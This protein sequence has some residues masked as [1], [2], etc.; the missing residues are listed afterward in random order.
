MTL[1]TRFLFPSVLGVALLLLLGAA[2]PWTAQAEGALAEGG[3]I[4]PRIVGGTEVDPPGKYP[5][6]V[7]VV[8]ASE[9]DTYWGQF[10]GGSL[11]AP[12]W[13]LTAGH[14]VR[15][16][17]ANAAWKLDVVVG[18]HDLR[19]GT[20]GER[21]G[22]AGIYRH[23]GYDNWTLANDLALLRLER[24]AT[25]GSP[26]DL[27]TAANAPLFST[28]EIA[29]V[30]GWGATYEQPPGTPQYPDELREVRVPVVS[31]IQCA[32]AY[33]SDLILPD[34]LC[35]GDM[36]FGGV[37]SC[38]GDSGGP[39]FVEVDAAIEP[40]YLHIGIVSSG[41]DCALPGWPGLYT[42]TANYT[43]W[44][45]S[46]LA[47]PPPTC[48]GVEATILGSV[49]DDTIEGTEGD[50]VIAA[51]A[52]DDVI[53]GSG[54]HDLI[55]GG[56]GDDRVDGGVGDDA[57]LG[58]AGNDRLEGAEGN[59]VLRGGPGDDRLYGGPGEDRLFGGPGADLALG[60]EGNDVVYGGGA[61]DRL[62]GGDGDDWVLGRSGDDFLRGG[63]GDDNLVGDED[64]DVLRGD[65]GIDTCYSGE[66]V[67]CEVLRAGSVKLQ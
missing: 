60:E 4:D 25:L 31:D 57:I 23:P 19:N 63:P 20:D 1:R 45:E 35:A 3:M 2:A 66:D 65:P 30:I 6:I 50:D 58:G 56:A 10:C 51:R 53:Y 49:G 48:E 36:I 61:Q 62:Y 12:Q 13:V 33:G 26:I 11:V 44:I 37:D 24:A 42:R 29:T 14:C 9:P 52:G 54:G 67:V 40:A 64:F 5:F 46:I 39:L 16:A 28:G 21:I 18:R 43:E 15:F 55:C 17:D 38:F 8:F 27:A 47:T 22:V 32:L 59:D 41:N 34:M 7:A